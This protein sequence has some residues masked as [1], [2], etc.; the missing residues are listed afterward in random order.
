MSGYLNLLPLMLARPDLINNNPLAARE[1]K[2]GETG[3]SAAE[4]AALLSLLMADSEENSSLSHLVGSA[5]L[6]ATAAVAAPPPIFFASAPYLPDQATSGQT[7]RSSGQTGDKDTARETAI[8]DTQTKSPV[9]GASRLEDLFR[10][11][12]AKYNLDPALLKAVARAE[13]A[14]NPRAVSPAGAAGV[15]QLMPATARALGVEN[16]FDPR[17]NIMAGARYLRQLLDRF[18]GNLELALAAYNAGP[19]AVEEHGGIP[20]YRETR[21][22]ISRVLRF[23]QLFA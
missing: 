1:P 22:Y 7:G 12:A 19:R 15:M 3:R 4:F 23:R 16:V 17:Q 9:A 10:E 13:S 6:R 11:A 21:Q 2:T 18:A 8:N 20:P 5:L 14:F